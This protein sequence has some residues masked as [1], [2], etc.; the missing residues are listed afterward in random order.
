MFVMPRGF[1]IEYNNPQSS[2]PMIFSVLYNRGTNFSIEESLEERLFDLCRWNRSNDVIDLLSSNPKIDIFY[3]DGKFFNLA[4]SNKSLP[5]LKSLLE[6][7]ERNKP[8]D[9]DHELK[10][11]RPKFEYK[12]KSILQKSL[13]THNVSQE[14]EDLIS[15][16]LVD[17]DNDTDDEDLDYEAALTL[18]SYELD[19]IDLSGNQQPTMQDFE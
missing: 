1:E 4:I 11:A 3:G 12:L 7:C 15:P 14:I 6:Y 10:D 9:Q 17:F 2:E 13:E 19:H 18:Y 8:D 16:Y 5:M